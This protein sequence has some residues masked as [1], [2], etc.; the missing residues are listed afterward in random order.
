MFLRLGR[1]KIGI[2]VD[3]PTDP[4]MILIVS[5]EHFENVTYFATA[6]FFHVMGNS[7]V[8]QCTHVSPR[9]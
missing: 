5:N 8:R 7:K 6:N 1:N 3:K 2:L 4:F 9:S